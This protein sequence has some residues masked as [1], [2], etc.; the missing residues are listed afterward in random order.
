MPLIEKAI[1]D[2]D[3][4]A[5]PIHVRRQQV[6]ERRA[7]VPKIRWVER[8]RSRILDS[9]CP[10]T[11]RSTQPYPERR[12]RRRCVPRTGNQSQWL[13]P[14]NASATAPSTA[15]APPARPRGNCG[16]VPRVHAKIR[17]RLWDQSISTTMQSTHLRAA[18]PRE[19]SAGSVR[20]A[21]C[22]CVT[23]MTLFECGCGMCHR[24][25][26]SAPE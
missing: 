6:D 11:C 10:S 19:I 24:S 18:A 4:A 8:D 15:Q 17:S 23:K 20:L 1:G 25:V 12:A 14:Q 21:F 16:L 7:A 22:P 5:V 13:R 26:T 9:A 3:D 2:K